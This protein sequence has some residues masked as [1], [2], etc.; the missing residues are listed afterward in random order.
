MPHN[1]PYHT[2]VEL[3]PLPAVGAPVVW[4]DWPEVPKR[5]SFLI[6][7]RNAVARKKNFDLL[8]HPVAN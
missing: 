6:L 2:E 7:V 1:P 5:D 3:P 4:P 8:Q